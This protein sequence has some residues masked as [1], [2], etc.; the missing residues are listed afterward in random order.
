MQ[1]CS[2]LLTTK[3]SKPKMSSTPM[4]EVLPFGLPAMAYNREDQQEI[5]KT[6]IISQLRRQAREY[7]VDAVNEI[8][9]KA[10]V[11]SL[12]KCVSCFGRLTC[13]RAIGGVGDHS[14]S[15]EAAIGREKVPR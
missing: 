10:I 4:K 9:E 5:V 3:F 13:E 11:Q 6:K 7:L 15:D 8:V 12:G 2:K 14:P 1:N